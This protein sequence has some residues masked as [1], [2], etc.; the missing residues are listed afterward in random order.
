MNLPEMGS[1]STQEGLQ[2]EGGNQFQVAYP[3]RAHTARAVTS[4]ATLATR[5]V[6]RAGGAGPAACQKGQSRN[7]RGITRSSQ[8]SPTE[9]ESLSCSSFRE[10]RGLKLLVMSREGKRPPLT[11]LEAVMPLDIEGN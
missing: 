5:N 2:G 9:E 1:P 4:I 8:P 11:M 7:K 10:E 6:T 3:L